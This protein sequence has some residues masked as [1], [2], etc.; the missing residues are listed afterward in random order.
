M[1]GN[2]IYIF[3]LR[4]Q[5][6]VSVPI[7]QTIPIFPADHKH[8]V[9]YCNPIPSFR[10][11]SPAL[12]V[13][14][15]HLPVFLHPDKS[16][17]DIDPVIFRSQY[18]PSVP[19]DQAVFAVLYHHGQ[20]VLKL[21]CILIDRFRCNFAIFV[22]IPVQAVYTEIGQALP[23]GADAVALRPQHYISL[24]IQESVILPQTKKGQA[25]RKG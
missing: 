17:R 21:S 12:L 4:L 16:V 7:Q 20:T 9:L 10:Q 18:L 23:K 8:S 13:K 1:I 6:Q 24:I 19:P 14:A 3:V 5:K 2:G 22:Q 11:A 25:L 15:V